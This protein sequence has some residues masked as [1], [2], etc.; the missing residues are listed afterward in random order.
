MKTDTFKRI[1]GALLFILGLLFLLGLL[2]FYSVVLFSPQ[3]PALEK[4]NEVF[5]L[6]FTLPTGLIVI[7]ASFAVF[8]IPFFS[9]MVYGAE[10][11]LKKTF[12]SKTQLL[13]LV[14][15]WVCALFFGSVTVLHQV[16]DILS[17]ISPF[18]ANP[19]SLNIEKDIP[20]AVLSAF[21]ATLK[22]EVVS[23]QGMPI[24]GFEPFMFMNAFPGL[25]PTDFE[26]VEASIGHYTIEEGT[27]VYKTDDTKLIH[28]AAKAVTDRGLDTLLGNVAVRLKVDLTKE[29]TLTEIMEALVRYSHEDPQTGVPVSEGSIRDDEGKVACTMDAKVCP[30][31]SVVGRVGSQCEF[32]ACPSA[33]VSTAHTCTPEEKKSQACT[34]EY[35]PVCGMVEVQCIKAPCNPVPQTFGN[36]CSACA[37]ENVDSYTQGECTG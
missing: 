12:F 29:G 16:E 31:G 14:I 19:V 23:N 11:L 9:I 27:L 3:W 35:A 8:A 20:L 5:K 37:Q 28:S 22:N 26:G 18:S 6:I 15:L 21:R 30:D 36:G 25:S 10:L 7:Y 34:M 33:P 13:L 4:A 2:F 32:A 17:R 24:E 1:C